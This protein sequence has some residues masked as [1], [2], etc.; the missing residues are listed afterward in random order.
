MEIKVKVNCA[1]P[2]CAKIKVLARCQQKLTFD[3][4]CV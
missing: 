4:N 2:R 1:I 3:K